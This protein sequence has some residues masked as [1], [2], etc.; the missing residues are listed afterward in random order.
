M[1]ILI[2]LKAHL[3]AICRTNC[4]FHQSEYILS[5]SLTNTA[6]HALNG[7]ASNQLVH[8]AQTSPNHPLFVQWFSCKTTV[9]S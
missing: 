1:S 8:D 3:K 9:T 2:D 6:A 7:D 4:L 5:A